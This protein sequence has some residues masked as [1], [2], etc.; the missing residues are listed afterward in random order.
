MASEKLHPDEI[1]IDH[2]LVFRLLTEQFPQWS[3]LSLKRVASPGTSNVIY[4]LG[5][6]LALRLPRT[7]SSAA[8]VLKEQTWLPFLSPLLP[9]ATPQPLSFGKASKDYPCPWSVFRWIEGRN[10]TEEKVLNLHDTANKLGQFVYALRKIKTKNGPLAGA[11][12]FNRGVPLAELDTTVRSSLQA[13]AGMIDVLAATGA[14]EK[15]LHTPKWDQA[16]CW[17]HGDIHAANLLIEKGELKAVIDFGGLGVGDPACDL[18]LAWNYL[19]S[20][21]RHIFQ[22]QAQVDE[23]TWAR[24]RGWALYLGL[25][26]LPYYQN[27]NPVLANIARHAI[28]EVLNDKDS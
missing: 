19:S 27:S 8:Q 20:D 5:N 23:H 28:H 9:L 18:M 4:R 22:K 10:A 15:A 16:P 24:G 11:H 17:I 2:E 6:D 1:S 13:L 26:A 14:W 7:P 3:S 25:V 12:N 21:T